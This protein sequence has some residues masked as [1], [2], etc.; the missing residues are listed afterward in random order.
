MRVSVKISAMACLVAA[1]SGGAY[2]QEPVQRVDVNQLYATS[3]V[4]LSDNKAYSVGAVLNKLR[5]TYRDT[6][7]VQ[8]GDRPPAPPEWQRQFTGR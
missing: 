7:I 2:A 3:T 1:I 8:T 4:C 5:C 6:M